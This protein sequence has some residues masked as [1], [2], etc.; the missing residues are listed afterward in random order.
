VKCWAPF[1]INAAAGS[2][3]DL[4][5]LVFAGNENNAFL[6]DLELERARGDRTPLTKIVADWN[7]YWLN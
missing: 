2:K 6:W 7:W 3:T 1:R 5:E 4:W